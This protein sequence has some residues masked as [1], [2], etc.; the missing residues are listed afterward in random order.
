M[1]IRAIYSQKKAELRLKYLRF[2]FSLLYM[3][4]RVGTKKIFLFSIFFYLTLFFANQIEERASEGRGALYFLAYSILFFGFLLSCYL[5]LPS[6]ILQRLP[7]KSLLPI[8][9]ISLVSKTQYLFLHLIPFML[10][11]HLKV[12]F[13]ER[14]QVQGDS[15]KPTLVKGQKIWIEKFTTGITLPSLD[16]PFAWQLP[17]KL[18]PQGLMAF[19]RG[20][21]VVFVYPDLDSGNNTAN[22]LDNKAGSEKHSPK[23]FIKRV[24]A[25]PK[26]EYKF[27]N[28]KI[29][30]EG[31][32]LE[33]SYLPLGLKTPLRPEIDSLRS[34]LI[35]EKL[36][37]LGLFFSYAAQYGLPPTGQVPEGNLLVL[38][39]E[40]SISQDSRTFGFVPI[41]YVIGKVIF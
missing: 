21:I 31:Q 4:I 37:R 35:P 5:A 30:I 25:L 38:G 22:T 39:D 41:S 26:E 32:A 20:D 36:T 27:Y 33:E 24:I 8:K 14:L 18:F 19:Q 16:F 28:G 15:M 9:V 17:A 34:R 29:Y 2:R 7:Y 1:G 23:I 40:R 11:F 12:C 6:R 3:R 13:I 10:I